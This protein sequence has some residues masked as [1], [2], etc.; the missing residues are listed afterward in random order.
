[1]E[2]VPLLE[3]LAN[4]IQDRERRL[5][6][7]APDRSLATKNYLAQPTSNEAVLASRKSSNLPLTPLE[8]LE[9]TVQ[10]FFDKDPDTASLRFTAI[11]DAVMMGS[12][13]VYPS[14]SRFSARSLIPKI[15]WDSSR[16]AAT[17]ILVLA[18]PPDEKAMNNALSYLSRKTAAFPS[19]KTVS[20]VA[21]ADFAKR[22]AK[23]KQDA[24]N[25]KV[26]KV[27]VL[28]VQLVDVATLRRE[29]RGRINL[30]Q[31]SFAHAFSVV[32][33]REGFRVYQAWGGE[34]YRLDE[35]VARGDS[36]L[37]TWE[38]G[39]RFVK[40]FSKLANYT[41]CRIDIGSTPCKAGFY[42]CCC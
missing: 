39:K 21:S 5:L 25:G 22:F 40:Q 17:L 30:R 36:R 2:M 16:L 42:E 26:G 20:K 19:V 4:T 10:S 27:T 1:M 15:P 37:R 8:E 29:E 23:A 24:V 14:I 41:V 28:A 34:G 9:I 7:T 13:R 35:Y 3:Y 33:G 12:T 38:E 6:F 18:A 32:I 31:T 11:G